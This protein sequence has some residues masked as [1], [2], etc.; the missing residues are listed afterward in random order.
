MLLRSILI[1]S[2]LLS[3]CAS[4]RGGPGRV[5]GCDLA[6]VV[7]KPGCQLVSFPDHLEQLCE[8]RIVVNGKVRT[9]VLITRFTCKDSPE[10][11]SQ[12]KEEK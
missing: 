8:Q 3:G 6:R 1:L 2:L 12:I 10:V 11:K 7:A 9:E 5:P 4:R